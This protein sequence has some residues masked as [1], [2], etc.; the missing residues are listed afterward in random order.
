LAV[1]VVPLQVTA[2]QVAQEVAEVGLVQAV[3]ALV[4]KVTMVVLEQDNLQ[5]LL[6]AEVAV[7]LEVLDKMLLAFQ[8]LVLEVLVQ[9]GQVTELLTLLVE[10]VVQTV[11][12]DPLLLQ[13]QVVAVVLDLIQAKHLLVVLV[14]LHSSI[15]TLIQL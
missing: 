12:L 15:Q 4:D 6:L 13:I 8:V 11:E 3:L 10:Q 1:A 7:V 5:F 14:L 9:F 2:Q